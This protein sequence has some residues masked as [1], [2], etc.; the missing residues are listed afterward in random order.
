MTL[1][2]ALTIGLGVTGLSWYYVCLFGVGWKPPATGAASNAFRQFMSLSL[3]TI[4][5]SLAT[6]VGMLLGVRG[7][8]QSFQQQV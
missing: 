1:Q 4:G 2:D 3:T 7:A 6:F 8:S 5:V